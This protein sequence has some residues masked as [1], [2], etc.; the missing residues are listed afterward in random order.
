M[1]EQQIQIQVADAG[2]AAKIELY[3]I[4]G[5]LDGRTCP[6]CAEWQDKVVSMHPDGKHETVQD[7]I[8]NHGFHYNCRCSLQPLEVEEI[9]LNPLNPRYE[10]RKAANPLAYNTT[11]TSML[12]FN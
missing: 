2:N 9:P 12:V 3:K 11:P 7:F 4:V 1:P 8:N 10:Q 6:H 5:T